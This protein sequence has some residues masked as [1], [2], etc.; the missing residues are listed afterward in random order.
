MSSTT[1]AIILKLIPVEKII[2]YAFDYLLK[3]LEK[4]PSPKTE[5]QVKKVI[6]A[7]VAFTECSDD[8]TKSVGRA[9]RAAIQAWAKGQ[10]TPNVYKESK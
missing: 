5:K 2:A 10:P 9:S 3:K 6:E 8:P 7:A 4:K 1:L